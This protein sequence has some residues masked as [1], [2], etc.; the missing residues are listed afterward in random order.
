MVKRGEIYWVFFGNTVGSEQNGRRPAL[1]IQNNPGNEF[2]PTTIVAALTT[3]SFLK[4]F[5]TNVNVPRMAAGLKFDSTIM[6]SQIQTIDQ[7]RLQKKIGQL[8][9]SFMAKVD[10]AIKLSL[11]L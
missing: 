9:H 1:I 7:T 10:S 2:S 6:L 5:P 8:P 3:K 11:G 4:F